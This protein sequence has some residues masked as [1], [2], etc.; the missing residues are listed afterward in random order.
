MNSRKILESLKPN[1]ALYNIIQKKMNENLPVKFIH[2]L[3][4]TDILNRLKLRSE[5]NTYNTSGEYLQS[6]KKDEKIYLDKF[7]DILSNDGVNP[8]KNYLPKAFFVQDTFNQKTKTKIISCFDNFIEDKTPVV[9]CGEKGIGKTLLQNII[10]HD[11]NES[12]ENKKIFWVRC[13]VHKLYELWSNSGSYRTTVE[14]YLKLQLLYVFCKYFDDTDVYTEERNGIKSNMFSEIFILLKKHETKFPYKIR[15]LIEGKHNYY[16][17]SDTI[18]FFRR[19]ILIAERSKNKNFSYMLDKLLVEFQ[20][21]ITNKDESFTKWLNTSEYLIDFLS[22]NNYIILNIIDGVD[23]IN[24]SGNHNFLNYFNRMMESI[25]SLVYLEPKSDNYRMY[26]CMRNDTFIELRARIITTTITD[27]RYFNEDKLII[28]NQIKPNNLH[29]IL[30]TRIDHFFKDIKNSKLNITTKLFNDIKNIQIPDEFKLFISMM[31]TRDY[32]YNQLGLVRLIL[33]RNM[34]RGNDLYLPFNTQYIRYFKR[35]LFLNGRLYLNSRKSYFLISNEGRFFYNIFYSNINQQLC[36][37]RI[38]QTLKVITTQYSLL[39]EFLQFAF[40]YNYSQ[41]KKSF[42]LLESFNLIRPQLNED[43]K[44]EN[45]EEIIQSEEIKLDKNDLIDFC[46]T[47]KGIMLEK[48][49]FSDID[50]LYLLALDTQ[51]PDWVLPNYIDSFENSPESRSYYIPNCIKS[52]VSFLNYLR[53]ID[54]VEIENLNNKIDSHIVNQKLISESKIEEL[55]NLIKNKCE[56]IFSIENHIAVEDLSNQIETMI[57]RIQ[58]DEERNKLIEFI[59]S[60]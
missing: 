10:L 21:N 49:I 44:H 9:L 2:P 28:L 5:G 31:S 15:H 35:N 32:L 46:I 53:L 16:S 42:Q 54:N 48:L 4:N 36:T 33:L 7:N 50:I 29:E 34:Q 51:V 47:E 14:I 57:N 59:E 23:N 11:Y 38:L 30:G 37:L 41:I 58:L 17:L 22:I 19:D 8:H 24:F 12:L 3:D 40:G 55:I 60:F 25:A 13:D 43:H 6:E 39:I 45:H 27:G 26:F 20:G 18:E 56:K 52:G 1:S